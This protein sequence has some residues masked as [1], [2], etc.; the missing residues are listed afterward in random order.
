MTEKRIPRPRDFI[1]LA[2]LIGD[3]ATRGVTNTLNDGEGAAAAE[4]GRRGGTKGGKARAQK[5][6]PEE[7]R[8]AAQEAAATRWRTT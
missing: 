8:A 3:M 1:A 7:Q 6:S 5:L 2:K 4:L